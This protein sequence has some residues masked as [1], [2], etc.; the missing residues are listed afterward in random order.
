[1]V[2]EYAGTKLISALCTIDGV[3]IDTPT[4]TVNSIPDNKLQNTKLR[5]FNFIFYIYINF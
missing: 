1:M 4:H 3:V 2:R 5:I